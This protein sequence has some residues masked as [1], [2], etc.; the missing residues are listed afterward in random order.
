MQQL[1]TNIHTILTQAKITDHW[2]LAIAAD[3]LWATNNPGVQAIH[4]PHHRSGRTMTDRTLARTGTSNSETPGVCYFSTSVLGNAAR[5]VSTTLFLRHEGKTAR[6]AISSNHGGP[7]QKRTRSSSRIV[8][9]GWE[10]PDRH[11][12]AGKCTSSDQL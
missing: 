7:A 1:L 10:F 11:R 4:G 2:E 3:V 5:P 6:L 12:S 9:L 8:F